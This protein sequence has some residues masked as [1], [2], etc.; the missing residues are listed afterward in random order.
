MSALIQVTTLELSND[1]TNIRNRVSI[2]LVIPFINTFSDIIKTKFKLYK[3]INDDLN[4]K[5]SSELIEDSIYSSHYNIDC[6]TI[7]YKEKNSDDKKLIIFENYKDAEN[8]LCELKLS[9]HDFYNNSG[10]Y[11]KLIN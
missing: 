4:I 7:T 9:I 5:P 10:D 6:Y 11:I 2:Y 3:C 8:F 1:N